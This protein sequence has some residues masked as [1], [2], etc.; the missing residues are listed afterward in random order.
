VTVKLLKHRKVPSDP[1]ATC[2]PAEVRGRDPAVQLAEAQLPLETALA[3]VTVI[4][5]TGIVPHPAPPVN[6]VALTLAVQFCV[7]R[8]ALPQ[9][10]VVAG[11]PAT[12]GSVLG[13]VAEKLTAA[14][15]TVGPEYTNAGRGLV[16]AF[17]MLAGEAGWRGAFVCPHA[18]PTDRAAKVNTASFRVQCILRSCCFY[19]AAEIVQVTT[20]L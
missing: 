5:E 2:T 4:A 6:P 10:I 9:V 1:P 19:Y 18:K 20:A 3:Q 7:P 8:E 16:F 15:E 12:L 13:L 17:A 14:E 11:V